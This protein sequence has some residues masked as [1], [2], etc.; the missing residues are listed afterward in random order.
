MD[1]LVKP[2]MEL[3]KVLCPCSDFAKYVC[4]AMHLKSGC[5][6]PDGGCFQFELDTDL[7]ELHPTDTDSE[8][9]VEVYG[10]LRLTH[11]H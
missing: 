6:G 3:A 11:S 9:D 1:A 4:N 2:L 5:C 7:V 10:C 8:T